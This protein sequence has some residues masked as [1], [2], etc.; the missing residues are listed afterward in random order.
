MTEILTEPMAKYSTQVHRTKDY[1]IFK[2][3]NG[4]RELNQLH[5]NRL[6]ESIKERPLPQ[7]ITVNENYEVIDGQ[8]RLHIFKSLGLPIEYV[9]REGW[10]L[11]EVHILNANSK[12]WSADEYLDG[13]CKLGK[14][15][16]II[17]K[18]FKEKYNFNHTDCMRLLS[19]E[20]SGKTYKKFEYGLFLVKD[21]RD[22]EHFAE[23]LYTIEPYF[24]DFKSS[25]FIRS[26]LRLLK[27]DN[28]S[29]TEFLQKLK[30]QPTALQTCAKVEQYISLIEEIYNYKRSNKVNLR[31]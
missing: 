28:F 11:D 4:N 2:L 16:Y 13:Y 1:S 10:G 31:Y 24:K 27:R 21:L 17:Y 9:I 23:L 14:E 19:G 20:D 26:I 29:F 7:I 25:T 3:L 30:I 5:L 6:T 8:H 18:D 15:D 22:A 12:N